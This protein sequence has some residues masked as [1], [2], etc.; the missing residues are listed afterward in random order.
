[1]VPVQG[2]GGVCGQDRDTCVWTFLLR[3]LHKHEQQQICPQVSVQ[4]TH[5]AAHFKK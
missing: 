4:D 1:M 3:Q 2:T 5:S